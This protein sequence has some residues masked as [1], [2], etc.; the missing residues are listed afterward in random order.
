MHPAAI[1]QIVLMAALWGGSYLFLRIAV[2][3]FGPVPLIAIRVAIASGCLLPFLLAR[4]GLRQEFRANLFPL[5]ILGAINAA[6][7][8]P[9]FAYATLYL[10]AGFAAVINAT[11]P[12]F[13]TLIAWLWLRDRITVGGVLGLCVGLVG[14]IILTGGLAAPGPEMMLAIA[15]AL[16]AS[17]CYGV[18]ASYVKK[19][20]S[21]VSSWVTT[22]GSLGFSALLLLP[23]AL[24]QWPSSTPSPTAWF[25][26]LALAIACTSVP[27]IFY[28]RLILNVGPAR[29]MTVAFLIPGFGML[30]GVLVLGE[31]V[32]LSM[33]AGCAVILLGTALVTG[34]LGSW[35]RGSEAGSGLQ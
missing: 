12:L 5:L 21:G 20:L 33:I 15:A 26:V 14:V 18:S 24:V 19:R 13:A 34:V 22:T 11:A 25:A 29:A 35:W 4:P 6:I 31:R 28:F 1:A 27:N 2:P 30:W 3:E 32:T 23:L 17:F 16:G 9:L 10:S 7:P 8:F